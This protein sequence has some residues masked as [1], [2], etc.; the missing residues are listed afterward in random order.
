MINL[1]LKKNKGITLIALVITIVVLLVLAVVAIWAV[2]D[3]GII[4]HS[5]KAVKDYKEADFEEKID[6][7]FSS[8]IISSYV[9]ENINY[10]KIVNEVLDIFNYPNINEETGNLI[11]EQ[12]GTTDSYTM[13]AENGLVNVVGLSQESLLKI[14]YN[15]SAKSIIIYYKDKIWEY[16][17]F[18]LKSKE[19]DKDVEYN[20]PEEA[21]GT[22]YKSGLWQYAKNESGTLTITKYLGTTAEELTDVVVPNKINGQTVEFFDGFG[23]NLTGTLTISKGLKT[24][25]L[26]NMNPKL[27]NIKLNKLVIE[28]DVIIKSGYFFNNATINEIEI[29]DNVILDADAIFGGVTINNIIIE[30]N[31]QILYNGFV[32]TNIQET[33]S[34]GNNCKIEKSNISAKKMI[35]GDNS[36]INITASSSL[37]ELVIGKNVTMNAFSGAT[38]LEN[39]T[40]GENINLKGKKLFKNCTL[41]TDEIVNDSFAKSREN[42]QC[43]G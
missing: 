22:E 33:I 25:K 20:A 39:V 42:I 12:L 4:K 10:K 38:S 29:K 9:G 3:G 36:D 11:D 30:N 28:E 18:R 21:V 34:L 24:L 6:L 41:L 1:S 2:E 40:V 7:I 14:K 16:E 27:A 19:E 8:H 5:T 31:V 23:K 13:T 43:C 32:S 26:Q 17:N 35:I 37:K 15:E